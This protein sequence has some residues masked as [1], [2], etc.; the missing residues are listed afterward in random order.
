M[1]IINDLPDDIRSEYQTPPELLREWPFINVPTDDTRFCSIIISQETVEKI[2]EDVK[3]T[4]QSWSLLTNANEYIITPIAKDDFDSFDVDLLSTTIPYGFPS[5][6]LLN[7][8]NESQYRFAQMILSFFLAM[9]SDIN[10]KKLDDDFNNPAW[11]LEREQYKQE[12][13]L[14][15]HIWYLSMNWFIEIP[16]SSLESAWKSY[17]NGVGD[18]MIVNAY[19]ENTES[20][21]SSTMLLNR[22]KSVNEYANTLHLLFAYL[23][24]GMMENNE[25]INYYSGLKK[26][27]DVILSLNMKYRFGIINHNSILN[28]YNK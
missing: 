24:D 23:N 3:E 11:V 1:V 19:L 16:Y 7:E 4:P 14:F 2:N 5:L 10:M 27:A 15:L 6:E 25:R 22:W 20:F 8:K 28:K 13:S 18:S 21:G 9:E 17:K 12:K 26:Y